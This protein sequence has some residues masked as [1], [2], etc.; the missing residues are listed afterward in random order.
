MKLN[1][2]QKT[3]V[4]HLEGP[5]LVIAGPGSGKTTVIVQR[6]YNLISKYGVNPDNILVIT[7][8][9]A[10]A[11]NMKERY[12]SLSD[13]LGSGITFCTLHSLFFR[14][15]RTFS[16]FTADNLIAETLQFE[17]IDN[18]I[19]KFKLEIDNKNDFIKQALLFISGIKT[20]AIKKEEL[21]NIEYS[22]YSTLIYEEYQAYLKS[23]RLLDFDDLMLY[24]YRLLLSNEESVFYCRNKFK[25]I[26]VDEFQDIC[27]MQ[28][29]IIRLLAH[30][31]NNVFAVGDDDQSIYS[32]RG[33][34]PSIM[35]NFERDFKNTKLITLDTNYRSGGLIV[36]LSNKLIKHNKE[37]YNKSIST[38]SDSKSYAKIVNVDNQNSQNRYIIDKI[39]DM[40]KKG[41]DYSDF[42]I[43]ARTNKETESL[44]SEL[45]RN[46]IAFSSRERA[47]NIFTGLVALDIL[48]YLNLA[49][50]YGVNKT[51]E[52][53]HLIRVMNKPLRYIKREWLKEPIIDLA[54]LKERVV[55]KDWVF[56]NVV[57]LIDN[58]KFL[59][60]LKPAPAIDYI[61]N[62]INYREHLIRYAKDNNLS[63][64]ELYEQA[65]ELKEIFDK[66]ATFEE[67]FLFIDDYTKKLAE[68]KTDFS[69]KN[70]VT[71]STFHSAKGLE[72]KNVFI[73]NCIDG[74]IPY[75]K[76]KSNKGKIKFDKKSLE[77]ERRLFYVSMTRA[78]DNLFLTV[79]RFIHSKDKIP[80]GFLDELR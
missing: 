8:T 75:S 7:F 48:A 70:S 30:P 22:K 52:R 71:V 80:S 64:D 62:T 42:A 56:Y 4:E 11:K 13:D 59:S 72:F 10:A 6:T 17:C 24:C 61:L 23:R 55:L 37:R 31:L 12:L 18:I 33:A 69:N 27:E 51:V 78:I 43:L 1:E 21:K 26:L 77:E 79:P 63:F 2:N 28:Y 46:N 49:Y 20:G 9:K 25:Y 35:L 14:I 19:K 74:N 65:L 41:Y 50:K 45:I 67:V 57:S 44:I 66:F 40:T 29:K 34:N 60:S 15:L 16:N 53:S 39:K 73:I 58:L 3:A 76:N 36:K 38:G 68:I 54:D 47:S 5:M 32:F